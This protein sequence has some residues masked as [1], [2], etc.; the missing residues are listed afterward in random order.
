MENGGFRGLLAFRKWYYAANCAV[1]LRKKT[2]GQS[3][4]RACDWLIDQ[5]P[6][7]LAN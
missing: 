1:I 6:Q 5:R 7:D 3:N 4:L 2:H